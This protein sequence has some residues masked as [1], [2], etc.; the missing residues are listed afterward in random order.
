VTAN[1]RGDG[2]GQRRWAGND[3]EGQR[4]WVGNDGELAALGRRLRQRTRGARRG[5]AGGRAGSRRWGRGR[6]ATT[7]VGM[8][9][10][11]WRRYIVSGWDTR[12]R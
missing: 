2:E 9:R 8:G 7:M 12:N 5:G 4:R 10:S 3:G 1:S 11:R 6:A